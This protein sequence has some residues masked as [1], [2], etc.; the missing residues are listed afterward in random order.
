MPLYQTGEGFSDRFATFMQTAAHELTSQ[1]SPA[2]FEALEAL[3]AADSGRFCCSLDLIFLSSAREELARGPLEFARLFAGMPFKPA[4]GNLVFPQ[5]HAG[6][7]APSQ[8]FWRTSSAQEEWDDF[9][10]S[11]VIESLVGLCEA[12]GF[13]G[14]WTAHELPGL[15]LG[16]ERYMERLLEP[17]GPAVLFGDALVKLLDCVAAC[18]HLCSGGASE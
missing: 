12:R 3:E 1:S 18:K 7:A 10:T 4:E 9:Y 17:V 14:R 8:P 16:I 13:G 2:A 5:Q 6:A 11:R 15:V